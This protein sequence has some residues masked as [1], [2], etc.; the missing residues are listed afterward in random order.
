MFSNNIDFHKKKIRLQTKKIT[1]EGLK[2][3][4]ILS[5]NNQKFPIDIHEKKNKI[6]Y[7][8][9]SVVY[10]CEIVFSCFSTI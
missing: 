8:D 1:S 6:F 5:V 3:L 4:P 10:C 7:Y 2:D 9:I